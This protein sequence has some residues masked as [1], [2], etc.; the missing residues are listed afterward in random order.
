MNDSKEKLAQV[1]GFFEDRILGWMISDLKRS[2]EVGTNFLT[3]LGCLVYTEVIGN[4]LPRFG[5]KERGS[6]EEKYFYRCFYRLKSSEYL[7]DIDNFL[8]KETNRSIYQS[9]RHH[10]AHIYVPMVYKGR[11][12][13]RVFMQTVIARDGVAKDP[14]GNSI[15]SPPIAFD[16]QGRVFLATRNYTEELEKAYGTFFNHIFLKKDK[17]WEKAALQGHDVVTKGR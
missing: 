4:F 16:T 7:I 9:F 14:Q 2:I 11:K 10:M 1:K 13:N 3:A 5:Q 6:A 8:K 15:K 17:E 12:P